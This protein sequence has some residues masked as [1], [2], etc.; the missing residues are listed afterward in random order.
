[1]P[2][3][4]IEIAVLVLLASNALTLVLVAKLIRIVQPAQSDLLLRTGKHLPKVSGTI[5]RQE[6]LAADQADWASLVLVFVSQEC[7]ACLAA[8]ERIVVLKDEGLPEDLRLYFV[9]IGSDDALGESLPPDSTISMLQSDI[10]KLNPARAV[11]AYLFVDATRRVVA[12]GYV[13][14]EDWSS[15]ERQLTRKHTA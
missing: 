12:S 14:D 6:V 11:P 7:P 13:G 15:F 4:L 3:A 10:L 9:Q 1:M 2:Q 5:N 8:I